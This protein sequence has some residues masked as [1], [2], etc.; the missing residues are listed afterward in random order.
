MVVV[1]VA[2]AVALVALQLVKQRPELPPRIF[3]DWQNPAPPRLS[4]LLALLGKEAER[5][6]STG[7]AA[8]Q[9]HN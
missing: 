8:L 1:V 9:H 5:A 7:R 2:V 3:T 6:G 4:Q